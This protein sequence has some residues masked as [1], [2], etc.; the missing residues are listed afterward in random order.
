MNFGVVVELLP[1]M[2]RS[3]ADSLSDTRAS[4]DKDVADEFQ[5]VVF[6]CSW[7][8]TDAEVDRSHPV[9]SEAWVVATGERDWQWESTSALLP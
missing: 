3:T 4:D 7:R 5:S 2:D 6:S 1:L 8:S 9:Y